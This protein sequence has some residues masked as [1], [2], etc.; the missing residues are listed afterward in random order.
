MNSLLDGLPANQIKKL[1][2]VQNAA[3]RIVSKCGFE[4]DIM[5]I[6]KSLHW[7]PVAFRVKYK[8]LTI[9]W[10]CLHDKA[11][12]YLTQVLIPLKRDRTLRSN[13]QLL[14]VIPKTNMKTLGDRSFAASAP[15]LWNAMPLK[16]RQATSINIFKK[17]LKTYLF[18]QAFRNV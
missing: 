15:S 7:L 5:P 14:L 1:Q 17:D 8:I 13:D 2:R 9:T 12:E 18:E 3:A 4:L 11:P 16:L 10:K 6:L